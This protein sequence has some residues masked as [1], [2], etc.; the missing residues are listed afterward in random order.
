MGTGLFVDCDQFDI[1]SC[2][3]SLGQSILDSMSRLLLVQLLCFCVL[4]LLALTHEL[5]FTEDTIVPEDDLALDSVSIVPL[6][7]QAR[8]PADHQRLVSWI[9]TTHTRGTHPIR[10]LDEASRSQKLVSEVELQNADLVEYYGLVS[11][12]CR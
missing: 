1:D 5:T 3:V 9:K 8:S 11:R 10:L 6:M 7:R 2:M 12:Q 4:G